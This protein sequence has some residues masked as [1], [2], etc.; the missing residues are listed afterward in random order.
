[1]RIQGRERDSF[2]EF[3][4]RDEGG[5]MVV[6][7]D[8][9]IGDFT[10]R[11]RSV[12]IEDATPFLRELDMFEKTRQGHASLR[13]IEDE[14]ELRLR[15]LD[16]AGHFWISIRITRR[17]SPQDGPEP[18]MFSGGFPFDA[19]YATGLFAGLRDLLTPATGPR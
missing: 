18:L 13:G 19:D 8:A 16:N 7:V 11:N 12:V 14:F 3:D 4:R 15:S 5:L 2:I 1:M 9:S 6:S 17:P 10:A